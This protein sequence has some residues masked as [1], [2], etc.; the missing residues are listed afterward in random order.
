MST[1]LE[2]NINRAHP[3]K[4]SLVLTEIPSSPL[5]SASDT[6]SNIMKSFITDHNAFMLSLLSVDLPGLSIGEAKIPTMISPVAHVDMVYNWEPLTTEMRIDKN[7]ITYKLLML[8]MHLIK[9][10]EAFNQFDAKETFRKT[11]TTGSIIVRDNL[12][13]SLDDDYS[14]IM[15]FDF[16][17]LRPISISSLPLNYSN[18]GDEISLTVNWLYS[19][20]M[21][22]KHNGEAFSVTLN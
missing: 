14:P 19:Y 16:F 4:F 5:L 1:N 6:E 7:Y 17:D 18:S 3:D 10:P 12:K 2:I 22:R 21:P 13:D 8:W 9:N 11:T 15:S 20:F